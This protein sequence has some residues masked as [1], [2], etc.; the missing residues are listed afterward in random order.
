MGRAIG[1]MLIVLSIS[2]V[3][4]GYAMAGE[5]GLATYEKD[6]K[7]IMAKRCVSCHGSNAPTIEEFDTNKEGFKK[8]NKGPRMDT[9]KNLMVFVNGKDTG[10]FMRRLDDGKNTKEGQP[11]NMYKWLG[12][13]DEERAKNLGVIK[14]WVGGW[15]LKRKSAITEGELKAIEA[16]E[17]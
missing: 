17:K 3:M 11:G 9:Y 4:V 8:Q 10:A 6:V 1:I 15:T 16:K 12:S 5:K 2:M 7:P 14:K 13:T